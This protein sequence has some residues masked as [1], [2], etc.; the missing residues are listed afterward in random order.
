MDTGSSEWDEVELEPRE[1]AVPA[2][3]PMKTAQRG[4]VTTLRCFPATLSG[5]FMPRTKHSGG[6]PLSQLAGTPV[7]RK[8]LLKPT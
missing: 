7:V 4:C 6:R 1:L 5:C 2:V 3:Q 8:F